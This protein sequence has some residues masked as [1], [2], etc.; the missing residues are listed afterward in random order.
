MRPNYTS[1]SII[2]VFFASLHTVT[3]QGLTLIGSGGGFA[4]SGDQHLS[5]SIGEPLIQYALNNGHW[6][7]EGYQQ[8]GNMELMVSTDPYASP[9]DIVVYPNPAT[10]SLTLS[11][12]DLS[13]CVS[14][15]V[16]NLIGQH[17]LSATLQDNQETILIEALHPGLY[18]LTLQCSDKQ[19]RTQSIIKL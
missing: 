11:G 6:L 5:Y 7:T 4:S 1:I 2:L 13:N 19:Y 17:M 3:A 8:P 14:V 12:N 18:I 9:S 10:S 16:H 15:H